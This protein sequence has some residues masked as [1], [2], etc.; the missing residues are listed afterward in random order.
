MNS[1]ANCSGLQVAESLKLF[2]EREVL[3]GT[4]IS[5]EDF[6]S[7]FSKLV[8][9]V[10]P[11]VDAALESREKMQSLIDAWYGDANNDPDDVGAFRSFLQKIG[12]LVEEGEPFQIETR[13]VD[14]EVARIAGPQLVV[15][16]SNARFAINAANARW[17]SLFDGLYGTDA[18][19]EDDGCERAGKYNPKRGA[20]VVSWAHAFLDQS[21]ALASM[22]HADVV[23]YRLS[24]DGATQ[25]LE[26]VDAS[27]A[28]SPLSQPDKFRA[29]SGEGSLEKI[30]LRNHGL[31]IEL[32][33]DRDH[34]VGKASLSGIKDVILEAAL[35]TIQDCEDSVAAVD[36]EDKVQVYRNWLGL[37]QGD[38][39][40]TFSVGSRSVTRTL[41]P[42]REYTDPNGKPLVVKGR[43]L[44][45]VRNVGYLM[46]TPA[47]LDSNG[48]EV[49]EGVLDA[50][51]TI[52]CAMHDLRSSATARNSESGSV[53]VVKPKMHG[54]QEAALCGDIFDQVED[55]LGLPRDTV[56]I[57]IMDEE[58]RTSVNLAECIRA[59]K[60][61]LVFI[62]TGFLDRTANEISTM[63][64]AGPVLPKGEMKS[65][66]WLSAYEQRNVVIG[67]Q[68]G[69]AGKAQIGKGMWPIPDE[70]H[71]MLQEKIAHPLAG[72]SC[73]WVPS[74]VAA[75][76]HATHYHQVDVAARHRELAGQSPEN[77]EQLLML[78][79]LGNRQ[80]SE[81]EI[82]AELENNIQGMLG[83]IV[84]W[85]EQG[86]G[87]SKVPDIN[88]VQLME[89]RA[90][91]RISYQHV[92]NW[93]RH[94]VIS[95]Q[96][97]TDAMRRLAQFVDEQNAGDPDY[98]PMASN[99][100]ASLA[101][102]AAH[103]LVFKADSQPSGY[104]E[105]LLH[106]YRALAKAAQA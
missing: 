96:Q 37:M 64:A 15:P 56:K 41:N 42:D 18:I 74:P 23:E 45:F 59:M 71:R 50:M 78:P 90:T 95:S 36:A 97:V 32:Q 73:A 3:P 53:Y 40:T 19:P 94:G 11:K 14:P 106:K 20:A 83:Y 44:M 75:T 100:D 98:V 84:R 77:V 34:P 8:Q 92:A 54:P 30:L 69:L 81:E 35:T 93:V 91:L 52:A 28:V 47:V 17:G 68:C 72:G 57:G 76:L 27:G 2:I 21:C 82:T 89:D 66:A 61:R 80:C 86:V 103:D 1:Y 33:I 26:A 9:D 63:R 51:V 70:M 6:W 46:T 43:S 102:Q 104:T 60:T 101:F 5:A 22:S 99:L 7:R 85:V 10:T 105:P 55:A 62:N 38:I 16:V 39:S 67:L 79:L 88:N 13:N 25:V 12:Y 29:Y 58:K 31:H 4:E 48:A 87:C 24:G 49:Y 65:S